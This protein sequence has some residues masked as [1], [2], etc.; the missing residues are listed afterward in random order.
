[1]G[2]RCAAAFLKAAAVSVLCTPSAFPKEPEARPD[3]VICAM[4]RT[5]TP[6]AAP[7]M[8]VE[9]PE[10]GPASGRGV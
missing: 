2:Q 1:M 8:P 10:P 7:S 6:E 4:R 5:V 3:D 9:G